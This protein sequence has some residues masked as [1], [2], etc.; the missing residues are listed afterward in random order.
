MES[1]LVTKWKCEEM[2]TLESVSENR[3]SGC[4]VTGNCP[5]KRANGVCT[6]R[7][8]VRF[9]GVQV[10]RIRGAKNLH[11]FQQSRSSTID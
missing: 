6:A 8:R 3:A 5:R 2:I 11:L 4:D 7:V 1:V 9:Y 10:T